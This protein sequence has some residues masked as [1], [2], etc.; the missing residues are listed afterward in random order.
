[1]RRNTLYRK[2]FKDNL[3]MRFTLIV[4]CVF[5]AT[6]IVFTYLMLKLISESAVQ[7]QM[8]IQRKT[9]ESISNYVESK[10]QSVQ[11]MIRD[12]YRDGSLASNTTFLLENPYGEYVEHRLDR[13][14]QGDP[15]T[16]NVV[17]YFQ[18]KIDDDPDIRSLMLYS[19][20]QQVMYYY[21]DRRQFDI[22]ATNAAHS[23]VPDSMYLDEESLVSVPNIWV[24][25]SIGMQNTPMFSVKIPIN[26]K[27]SLLN[28]GQMLVYFDSSAIWQAMNNYKA[29][30]KGNILVLS[31]Q[32]EV[33]FDTSGAGYGKKF[34]KLTGLNFGEEITVDGM[35]VTS[36]TQSQAG[37]S[38]V[39]LISRQELAETYRSAR[40]TILFIAL[41]CILFAVLLP[42]MFISNFAKR[43]HRI[44]RFTRRVKNGDLNTR[45]V[46]SRE[47]ELGQI[48]KSFNS[49]LD[50]LNQYIDQVYKAEIRQKHTEIAT[51]EAR[52]NPHFLYNTLEVI[53]MRAISSGAKDVGEMIYS[54]SVLFKAYVR[55]KA[56]YTFK[57]ELEACRMY[58][59]LFRIRYKDRFVY[60]IECSKELEGL[61]VLKMSLQPVIENYI[62]HGMRTGQ[63][64]NV[65]TITV[66]AEN[67]HIRVIV[68][69]NG[70]GIPAERLSQLRQGLDN[71]GALSGSE[72]FGL[73]SIHERL[74]LMYGAPF[75]VVLISEEGKGTEVTLT[76]PYP[77]KEE[78]EHV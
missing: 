12:V 23:Y 36:L 24:L 35:V 77:A 31:A 25:K 45:I 69:D 52:V 75:G 14:L 57:D 16:S 4:S 39:S 50:E 37:Y 54:L 43:T 15:S 27:S 3:F 42:A 19:A 56:R 74:R 34:D 62:L 48:A 44:I 78:T 28:I 29:E 9:M 41:I 6:I 21:Q 58:L 73:R 33:I 10:Y 49:M 66:A 46:D 18:N 38:V 59:E 30:F 1:M 70:L 11:D 8:D 26:N 22:V 71:Q 51:L 68:A 47:D 2:Y 7:R 20:N 5:V 55:P 61:S 64:G 40:N 60:T 65:I 76:F 32:N 13:Y 53:R 17:Q 67:G 63:S 72:S